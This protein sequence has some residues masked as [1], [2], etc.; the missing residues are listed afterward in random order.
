MK[1]KVEVAIWDGNFVYIS[2]RPYKMRSLSRGV[3]E[4]LFS[5]FCMPYQVIGKVGLAKYLFELPNYSTIHS[6]FHVLWLKK[7]IGPIDQFQDIPQE[8]T[9][10]LEWK[11]NQ[12]HYWQH[13]E[14]GRS[15]DILVKW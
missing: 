14:R 6:I 7:T 13:N 11:P 3:N 10:N 9:W 4:K 2:S 1:T 12:K 15:F 5:M 8:L